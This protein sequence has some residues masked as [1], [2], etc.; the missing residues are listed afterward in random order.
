MPQAKH[1][2]LL[3][4]GQVGRAV[5]AQEHNYGR[6]IATTRNPNRI[7][8]LADLKIE[9]LIMPLPSAEIIEPL[10]RDA[11]VLVSFPPDSST[12]A[13]LAPACS[14]AKS[15]I[16]LSSTGVYGNKTGKIDDT[17]S[18]DISDERMRPR[19]SA[20]SIWREH[21][22]MVLRVPGIYGPRSGLHLRLADGSYKM[23]ADGAN[24]VSRIH[25][26]D[27]AN[28]ILEVFKYGRLEDSTYLLGDA[29]PCTLAEA[30][31]WLCSEM[32][33]AMPESVPLKE[34]NHTLRGNRAVDSSR[35]L[36]EIGYSLKYPTFKEGYTNC[37]QK[38]SQNQS[39]NT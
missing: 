19:L 9:P 24:L 22:A 16:Y 33:V 1:L 27:L 7:F 3:G 8:E 13:I 36:K 11:D 15:I 23:P 17:V 39:Q 6:V 12:D 14:K 35:L 32:K 26:E 5:I 10:V 25:I 31:T 21:G 29:H 2:V 30:V 18:P 20:E 4:T 37:L 38:Q 28:I 34:V